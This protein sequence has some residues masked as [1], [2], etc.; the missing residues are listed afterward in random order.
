ML[1]PL[2]E[3]VRRRLL[4]LNLCSAADLRVCRRFV[5][6]LASDLPAF[7]SVWLDGL[8]QMGR[9]T[10]YQ[11][12]L[13]ETDAAAGIQ[14]GPFVVIE[15]LGRGES[16]ETL[17]A[18]LVEGGQSCVLKLLRSPDLSSQEAFERLQELA[19][20]AAGFDHP[21]IAIASSVL[22]VAAGIVVVSRHISGSTLDE[23]LVRRGRFPATVV[24]EIGRQLGEGLAA[25]WQR[26]LAHGDI[27]GANVRVMRSGQLVLV[28]AGIRAALAPHLTIHTGRSPEKYDGVA[29]EL[30]GSSTGPNPQSDAYALGCQ[31]WQLLAGRPPFP[32]GDPLIKLAAHQT[33]AIEDVRKWAPET[34]QELAEAIGRLTARNSVERPANGSDLFSLWGVA[35]LRGRRRLAQFR[36]QFDTSPLPPAKRR[37]SAPTRWLFLTVILF[38]LTGLV[39]SLSDLGAR[40]ALLEWAATLSKSDPLTDSYDSLESKSTL[41]VSP[42]HRRS[43]PE[44]ELAPLPAPDQHGVIRLDSAGPYRASAMTTVGML[45]IAGEPGIRPILVVDRPLKLC[46]EAVRITNVTIRT[47]AGSN[48]RPPRLNALLLVQAQELALENCTFSSGEFAVPALAPDSSVAPPSGPALLAWKLLDP[49]EPRGGSGTIRNCLLRGDGPS[50]YL[51][52]A[53]RE[54][55]FENVLKIGPGPLVQLAATPRANKGMRLNLAHTTCRASGAVVRWIVPS[56]GRA[57]G[58][59][60]V[61]AADCVFDLVALHTALF[62]LAG[63]EPRAELLRSIQMMGE[64]S[65][66]GPGLEVAAWVSTETG[67][68]TALDASSLALEGLLTIPLQFSGPAGVSPADSE[69]REINAPRRS[70]EPPGIRAHEVP[71][72]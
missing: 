67:R 41:A 49:G 45:T 63:T 69:L 32:G 54:L 39:V 65:V 40:T 2:S 24:H 22:R 72:L 70:G 35:G 25:L 59:V 46:A 64:G 16:F 47:A 28:D 53:I 15:R 33:R 23:L 7:D 60:L 26:G 19:H 38:A 51:A 52:N 66:A 9:L 34:P 48:L 57:G 4:E 31:L 71:S 37:L 42:P 21:A 14:I 8:V 43:Q 18:R 62:E 3:P 13:L 27:R 17:R 5:R 61:E 36:R 10:P 20:R 6:R 29:P 30:I 11:S 56:A 55:D 44:P 68:V 58:R 1:E 50:L 12:R